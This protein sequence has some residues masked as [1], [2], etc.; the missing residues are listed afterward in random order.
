LTLALATSAIVVVAL[1]V[2][3]FGPSLAGAV[4]RRVER[5]LADPSPPPYDPGRQRR[6][7]T[8]ARE[9][10]R[11]VVS[12]EDHAM[13]AELGFIAV[14]GSSNGGYGYLLYPHRPIVAYDTESGELLNEYCVGFP[15]RSDPSLGERLPDADDV[16][17]KWMSLRAGERELISLANMHVPGRQIDPAQVRRDLARL[18][19]WRARRIGTAA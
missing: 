3:G 19:D 17:A 14:E 2:V 7:E 13:Y 16:L 18:R 11:A 12:A 1:A 9:L 6:A 8:R 5:R 10:L 15:D 4:R